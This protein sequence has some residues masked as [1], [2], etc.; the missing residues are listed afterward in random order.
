[1]SDKSLEQ[2]LGQPKRILKYFGIWPPPED[3]SWYGLIL[4]RIYMYLVMASQYSFLLFEL[5]YIAM[6]FG[7]LDE[8]FESSFLLFTQASLCY[9]TTVFLVNTKNLVILMDYMVSDTFAPQ[10]ELH[11]KRLFVQARIIRRLCTFFFTSAFTTCSLWALMPLFDNNG[12]RIFPF[13]IWMPV[14]PTTSPQYELGYLYQIVSVYI[15]AA[16]FVGVDNVSLAMIMYGTAQLEIIADKIQ[17][18]QNVPLKSNK[19]ER[20]KTIKDNNALLRECVKQHQ[21]VIRY[22]E[23]V[24]DTY[25]ANIFFQLSGTVLIICI[26]GLQ[27]SNLDSNSVQFV[28]MVTYMTTMLSQLFLYCWCGQE[29]T[30]RSERLRELLYQCPWYQQ[31]TRFKRS[32]WIAMERMK[33]PIIFRAGHY[34]P[35]SRPTFVSILRSSYS[36]FAVLNQANNKK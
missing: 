20:D 27:L 2:F 3:I 18:L 23:V 16:L 12:P 4:Y 26:I 19:E 14:G 8:M 32:L 30:I 1:M 36:Y 24:E 5:V 35:L 31:D 10:N 11:E 25:H 9:K 34:I 29:L 21:A 7:D 17:A 22:I 33:R 15:S 13:K 6:V 28:S